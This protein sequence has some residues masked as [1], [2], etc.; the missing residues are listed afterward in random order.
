MILDDSKT[1]TYHRRV[2]A[3]WR[4]AGGR[5]GAGLTGRFAQELT[6]SVALQ[7]VEDNL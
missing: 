4:T 6:A 3:E 2:W 1:W 5:G 7:M